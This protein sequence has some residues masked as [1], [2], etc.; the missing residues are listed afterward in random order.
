MQVTH[1]NQTW[2]DVCYRVPVVTQ[3]K[4]FDVNSLNY[5]TLL[6]RR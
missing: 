2:P 4:C 3:P 1:N 5:L 6:G